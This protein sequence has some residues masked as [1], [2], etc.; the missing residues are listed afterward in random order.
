MLDTSSMH[1]TEWVVRLWVTSI[2]S[3]VQS[4]TLENKQLNNKQKVSEEG[5]NTSEKWFSSFPLQ[6]N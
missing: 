4:F 1:I 2:T 3:Q 5:Y 6:N